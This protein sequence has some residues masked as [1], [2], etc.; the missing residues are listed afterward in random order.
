MLINGLSKKSRVIFIWFIFY[1]YKASIVSEHHMDLLSHTNGK[2]FKVPV[3]VVRGPYQ[4]CRNW[5]P[6]LAIANPTWL[7][8]TG[9]GGGGEH[10]YPSCNPA[11]N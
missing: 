8:T 7:K 3:P 6:K 5:S 2:Y 10:C 4:S 11:L 1:G 9:S